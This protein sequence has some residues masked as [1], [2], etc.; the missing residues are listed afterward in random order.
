MAADTAIDL[1]INHKDSFQA[2]FTVKDANNVVVDLTN[3]TA[4]SKF[5]TEYTAP[6]TTAISFTTAIT[7]PA[8]D[9]VITISLTAAQTA[10]LTIG[11]KYVYDVAITNTITS[12]KTRIVQGTIKVSPGVT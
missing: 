10:N 6:D 11:Q 8:T 5:K 2:S 3:Y 1:I 7:P 9:G 12:Y 4:A